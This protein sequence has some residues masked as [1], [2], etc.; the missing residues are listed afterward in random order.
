MLNKEL[1]LGESS[2]VPHMVLH[3]GNYNDEYYGWD[4]DLNMGAVNRRPVWYG[5]TLR[6]LWSDPFANLSTI[7]F[8]TN[9]S[10][11]FDLS[12]IVEGKTLLFKILPFGGDKEVSGTLFDYDMLGKRIAVYFDPPPTGT[13]IQRRSNRSRNMVL[14]RRRSLG[15]SRC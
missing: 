15:G 10:A 11:G 3:V 12:A 9:Q 6:A 8:T 5:Y 7:G 13:W 4:D 14:C 2:D 1:L